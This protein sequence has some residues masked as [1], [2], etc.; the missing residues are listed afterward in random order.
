[1]SFDFEKNYC[2]FWDKIGSDIEKVELN[3]HSRFT[4]KNWKSVAIPYKQNC[5]QID[6]ILNQML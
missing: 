2:I 3:F 5:V 4:A 1:M 6:A